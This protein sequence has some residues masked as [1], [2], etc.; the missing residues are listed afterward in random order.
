MKIL[1]GADIVPTLSNQ[2][3]FEEEQMEKIV[4]SRLVELLKKADYRVFN[5]EVPLTD[6]S[7]PIEKAGPNL[8]ASVK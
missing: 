1:I 5:L 8:I 2:K 4:D 3:Y 6:Q 7:M